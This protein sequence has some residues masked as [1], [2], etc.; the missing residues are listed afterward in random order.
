[1]P[2][3][4]IHIGVHQR[5]LNQAGEEM[6][7]GYAYGSEKKMD[8]TPKNNCDWRAYRPT[9]ESGWIV[10]IMWDHEPIEEEFS[11]EVERRLKVSYPE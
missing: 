3:T 5:D 6:I 11:E 4:D 8:E 10:K 1:M 2:D 9:P 7:D